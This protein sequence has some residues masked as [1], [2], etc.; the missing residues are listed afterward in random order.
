MPP[1]SLRWPEAFGAS[2][3]S[4]PVFG[5]SAARFD[6]DGVTALYQHLRGL[7]VDKGLP[8]GAGVLTAVDGKASTGLAGVL[9]DDVRVFPGEAGLV[10]LIQAVEA[11]MVLI[12]IVGTAGLRPALAAIEAGCD[13]AGDRHQQAD[14]QGVLQGAGERMRRVQQRKVAVPA[15]HR[16]P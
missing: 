8:A 15:R 3:E 6:D 4:M 14:R 7:L 5:T 2:W 13:L 9:P 1:R 16:Q 10:E 11:D 12:A